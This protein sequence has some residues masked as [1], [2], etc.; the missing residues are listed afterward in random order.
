LDDVDEESWL[1][2]TKEEAAGR[3][4]KRKLKACKR[5]TKVGMRMHAKGA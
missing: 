5:M 2:L 1:N 3:C 4:F